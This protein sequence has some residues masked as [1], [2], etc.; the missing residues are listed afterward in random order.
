MSQAGPLSDGGARIT[1]G[2]DLVARYVVHAVGPVYNDGVSGER[3]LLESAY[4]ESLL[5]AVAND[6]SSVAFPALSTGAY[7]Y[8][9]RY[10]AEI[11]LRTVFKFL[12]TERHALKSVRFVLFDGRALG[13]F[14]KTL[15][16]VISGPERP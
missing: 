15:G 5:L 7:R 13:E 12:E 14:E 8:P 6:L 3:S 1:T 9:L 2:G 4:R 10:A 11:A 16:R